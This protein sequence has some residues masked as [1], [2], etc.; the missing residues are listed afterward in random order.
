MS[1]QDMSQITQVEVGTFVRLVVCK[2]NDRWVTNE[3]SAV[4]ESVGDVLESVGTVI[5]NWS[6]NEPV[7]DK[8]LAMSSLFLIILNRRSP[9][10]I[11]SLAII[12]PP[13][14]LLALR[15]G[16]RTDVLRA[17]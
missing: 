4:F 9:N 3:H 12:R 15:I 17:P 7:Y 6:K 2:K 16:P 14:C 5:L 1:Q 13:P 8:Q 11:T 10:V